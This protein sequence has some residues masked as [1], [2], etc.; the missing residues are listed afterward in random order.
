MFTFNKEEGFIHCDLF[1]ETRMYP[2]DEFI[3]VDGEWYRIAGV[4]KDFEKGWCIMLRSSEQ[5]RGIGPLRS[6]V[7]LG[8]QLWAEPKIDESS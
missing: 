5:R 6:Y 7:T 2:Q 1:E 3:T 8:D 4:L